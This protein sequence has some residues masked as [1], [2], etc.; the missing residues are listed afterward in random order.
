MVSASEY[1]NEYLVF[2]KCGEF[3]DWGPVSRQEVFCSMELFG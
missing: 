1:S 3:L 2:I